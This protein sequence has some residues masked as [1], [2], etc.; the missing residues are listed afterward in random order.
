[1]LERFQSD[2][3]RSLRWFASN[4]ITLSSSAIPVRVILL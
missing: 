3:K 2:R 4:F 1:M